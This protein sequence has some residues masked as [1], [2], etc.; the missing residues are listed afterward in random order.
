MDQMGKKC[1]MAVSGIVI[2]VVVGLLAAV[3]GWLV[4]GY[5]QYRRDKKADALIPAKEEAIVV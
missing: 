2:W 4:H 3:V 1:A 5:V